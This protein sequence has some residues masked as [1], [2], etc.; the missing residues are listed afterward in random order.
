MIVA[1]LVI[2]HGGNEDQPI[3]ALLHDAV[4]DQGGEKTLIEV[5]ATFRDAV[6]QIVSDCTGAWGEPEPPWAAR[7]QAYLASLPSKAATGGRRPSTQAAHS[8]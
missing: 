1:A 4:E 2:E 6:A 7:K 5:K 8:E 3:A